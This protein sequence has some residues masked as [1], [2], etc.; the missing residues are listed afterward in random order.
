MT[1]PATILVALLSGLTGLLLGGAIANACVGWHHVSSREGASGFLVIYGALAGAVVGLLIGTVSARLSG[2]GW[3]RG[4][5][6]AVSVVAGVAGLIAILCRVSADVPPTLGGRPLELEVEFRFPA[7]PDAGIPPTRAGNWTFQLGT[8]TGGTETGHRDGA[9]HVD[10]SRI[11]DGRW[12]VPASVALFTARGARAI[13]LARDGRAAGGFLVP[14]PARPG[15]DFEVWS[16]WLPRGKPGG[17]WPSNRLDYRFRIRPQSPPGIAGERSLRPDDIGS[18]PPPDLV[19]IGDDQPVERWFP[20]L[21][22]GQPHEKRALQR[23]AKREHLPEELTGLALGPDPGIAAA[24]LR[25]LAALPEPSREFSA[26]VQT[27]GAD[28]AERLRRFNAIPAPADPT[29]SGAA[30]VSLRFSGWMAAARTLRERDHGD[31]VPEL[32]TILELSRIRTDSQVLQAD[33]RRVASHYLHEWAGV[34]PQPDD[35]PPR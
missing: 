5:A 32:K 20:Y 7:T 8:V 35:P 11:E 27:A 15:H 12:I 29:F 22:P 14:L 30:D 31:F 28:I 9:V 24:A 33:V 10:A 25:C 2:P 13:R 4:L 1:W 18:A 26:A 21:G 34:E 3:P 23:I 16:D 6:L 17:S 19:I